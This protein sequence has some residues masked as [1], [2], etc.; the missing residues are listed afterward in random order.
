MGEV[1]GVIHLPFLLSYCVLCNP[2][3]PSPKLSTLQRSESLNEG[4]GAS[5]DGVADHD[6]LSMVMKMPKLSMTI[7]C[8]S[9]SHVASN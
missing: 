2:H 9:F 7:S 8:A 3:K 5:V 1:D 6:A 4:T